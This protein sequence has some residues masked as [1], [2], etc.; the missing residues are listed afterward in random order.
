MAVLALHIQHCNRQ[1]MVAETETHI[2]AA[3][4]DLEPLENT[5][6][7]NFE[8]SSE[9]TRQLLI[10]HCGSC[11]QSTLP[12]HKTGAIAVF[13]LDKMENWHEDL[14]E[15][16]LAGI[17]NRFTNKDLSEEQRTAL[18]HFVKMKELGIRN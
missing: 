1:T 16:N 4:V 11:H 2:E 13:D 9:I 12:S 6:E 7:M 5:V 10:T 15:H 14:I 8:E 18:N 17:S 3:D